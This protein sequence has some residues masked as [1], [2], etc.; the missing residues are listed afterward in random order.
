MFPLSVSSPLPAI[1]GHQLEATE[2]LIQVRPFVVILFAARA[3]AGLMERLRRP[4][5]LGELM[6]P[7]LVGE[8]NAIAQ[9]TIAALAHGSPD[10]VREID[11]QSFANPQALGGQAI[12][13]A[14][15]GVI[16]PFA[17]ATT[18]LALVLLRL[19]LGGEGEAP[20]L[21]SSA[22]RLG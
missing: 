13:E 2:T 1:G 18:F 12:T 7:G 6:V 17:L 8:I 5:I 11:D 20:A 9:D 10:R 16:L 21:A 3:L 14:L 4:A 22:A 15:T 19:V